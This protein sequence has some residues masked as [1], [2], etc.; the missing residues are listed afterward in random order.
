MKDNGF[1]LTKESRRYPAQ[2]I[3]D[4]DYANDIVFL[5]NS[6]TQ[7][8]TL[9]HSLERAAAGVGLHV[10]EHK[11]EYTCFNQRSDIFT[12]NSRYLKTSTPTKEAVSY[13]PRETS[14]RN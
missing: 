1:K 2:T 13:Q 12:L 7:A 10:N 14:T 11:T 6:P 8:E 3:T 4:A 9:L 5:A